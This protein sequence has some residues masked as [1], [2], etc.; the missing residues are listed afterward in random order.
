MKTHAMYSTVKLN[1]GGPDMLV[2]DIDIKT[3]QCLCSWKNDNDQTAEV[4]Y[5]NVC[6]TQIKKETE[7]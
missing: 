5:P 3:N 7:K 6:L 4:W 2:V 1:S